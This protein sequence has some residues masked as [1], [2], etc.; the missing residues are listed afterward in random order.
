MK[1]NQENQ[2]QIH[3]GIGS[4]L[5]NAVSAEQTKRVGQRLLGLD[6]NVRDGSEVLRGRIHPCFLG[7]GIESEGFD[8]LLVSRR[9]VVRQTL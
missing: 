1:I 9:P 7:G 8:G 2:E 5:E 6:Q 3:A 4:E